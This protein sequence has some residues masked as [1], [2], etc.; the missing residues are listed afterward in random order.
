MYYRRGLVSTQQSWGYP[1]Q[2]K[3]LNWGRSMLPLIESSGLDCWITGSCAYN[4][5]QA[6]DLDI[7][8]T[9]TITE[10]VVVESLLNY[11]VQV[12]FSYGMLVDCRWCASLDTIQNLKAADVDFIYLDYYEYDNGL[13]QRE[14]RDYRKNPLY[15]IAGSGSVRGNFQRLNNRLKPHQVQYLTQHGSLPHIKLQNFIKDQEECQDPSH[16]SHYWEDR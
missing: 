5:V 7:V 10:I 12:G 6:K 13:G 16:S 1:T 15:S 9:G 8:Y 14:I 3:I 11:S 4:I 2:H